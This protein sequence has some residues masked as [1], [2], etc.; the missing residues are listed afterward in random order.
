MRMD[1][2]RRQWA[3]IKNQAPDVADWLGELNKAFGKPAALRVELPSGEVV[4]SGQF[5]VQRIVFDGK[6][7]MRYGRR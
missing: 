3:L 1:E 7:R 6:A 5:G 2:K 4:E